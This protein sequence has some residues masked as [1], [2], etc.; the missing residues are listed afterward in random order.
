MATWT[1]ITDASLEPGKP[2]RSVD[3]LALRDN[4]IAIARAEAGAPKVIAAAIESSPGAIGTYVRAQAN[5]SGKNFG[6]SVS[7]SILFPAGVG[8]GSSLSGTW[9][10]YGFTIT[11]GSSSSF[12]NWLRVL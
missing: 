5:T 10:L 3:L 4:T 9:V 6:D 11:S 1:D 7:G 2:V 8:N 12:G